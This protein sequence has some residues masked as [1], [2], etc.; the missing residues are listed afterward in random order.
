MFLPLHDGV[1]LKNMK[2]PLGTRIV[3]GLCTAIYLATFYGPGGDNE[4]VAGLGLI[5]GVIFGTEALPPGYPFVPPV[6]TLVTN[7]FVHVTWFHLLG[8]MLFLW[9]FGDNVEDA[10]GHGRFL[11]FFVLC[12]T[13]ASL[14]HALVT[15]EPH[16]PLIGASG[17]VSGVVAAYLILYPRVRIWGLF[18]KGIPLRMPAYGAIGF[19]FALQ[20]ASAF[21]GGDEAV[22]WFAHLGGFVVGAILI[23]VMR[24]RYDPVLAR[25][26]AQEIRALR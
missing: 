8:N 14:V 11:L 25:V 19:W 2:T 21:L 15:G 23:P 13:V 1:P 26:E 5:P 3:I 20:L 17:G 24:H 18:L 22:G 7:I 4:L 12:G 10:M 9:V 6:L 16:R